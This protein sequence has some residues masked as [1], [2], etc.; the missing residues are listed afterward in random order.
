MS[1]SKL[2]WLTAPQRIID[3]QAHLSVLV[4]PRLGAGPIGQFDLG[5]WPE[6]LLGMS[7]ELRTRSGG[8]Q[9]PADQQPR[10]V[11]TPDL[12]VWQAFFSGDAGVVDDTRYRPAPPTPTVAEVYRDAVQTHETHRKLARSIAERGGVTDEAASE[13]T[14]EWARRAPRTA[15]DT[16]SVPGAPHI[17]FNRAV[18]L[19]REHP[20]VMRA[21]GL[22]FDLEI[23]ADVLK[24][25]DPADRVLSVTSHDPP[26]PVVAPW[27]RY[28]IAYDATHQRDVL[29]TADQDGSFH[30]RGMLD[31]HTARPVSALHRTPDGNVP[32]AAEWVISTM[33]VEGAVG[34]LTE[35]AA[36]LTR[37]D[38]VLLPRARSAGLAL[39]RPG[40]QTD[41]DT[42]AQR[43]Q[44]R[45]ADEEELELASDD[46]LLGY[47]VDIRRAGSPWRSVCE[48]DA[49]YAVRAG[50]GTWLTI[51]VPGPEE[52]HVKPHSMLRREDGTLETDEVV[53]RWDGWSLALPQPMAQRGT[54]HTPT[55]MPYEF[56]WN[57][58]VPRDPAGK[59]RATLPA[60]RFGERYRM[61]VRVEDVTGGGPRLEEA[62]ME[63]A[64]S[65]QVIYT[66]HE[67]VEPPTLD[68]TDT[69]PSGASS[70]VLV[71]SSDADDDHEPVTRR[72]LSPPMGSFRLAEQHRKFDDPATRDLARGAFDRS[73]RNVSPAVPDPAVEG[74]CA[75]VKKEPGGLQEDWSGESNW[76]RWPAI[77][78]KT[79]ELIGLAGPDAETSLDFRNDTLSVRLPRAEQIT[80]ELSSTIDSDCLDHF[81]LSGWI[82]GP[83]DNPAWRED[84][85][86]GRHP[87]LSTVRRL[88]FIHVVKRPLVEPIWQL[89]DI[90]D[91]SGRDDSLVTLAREPGTAFVTLA[92]TFE[93]SGLDTDST[94]RLEVAARWTEYTDTGSTDESVEQLHAATITRGAPQIPAFRHEFGDTKHRMITY[95]LTA[96]SRYRH[97]FPDS[98]TDDA[99]TRSAI[100]PHVVNV[101][102]SARPR[103]PRVLATVPAFE[104]QT[105][106]EPDRITRTRRVALRVE[107]ARPWLLTGEGEQLAVLI[108]PDGS[109][110]DGIPTTRMG[111]DPIV[112]SAP[113]PA[114]PPASWFTGNNLRPVTVQIPGFD[115][116]LTAIPHDV[117]DAGDH[118]YA[119]VWLDIPDALDAY[120]PFVQLVVARYQRD[121]IE[122]IETSSVV[123]CD[124]IRLL[125]HRRLLVERTAQGLQVTVTGQGPSPANRVEAVLDTL[126]AHFDPGSTDLLAVPDSPPEPVAAWRAHTD[127]TSIGS[128]GSTLPPLRFPEPSGHLRLRVREIDDIPADR[129]AVG[130]PEITKQTPYFDT[131]VLPPSWNSS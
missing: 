128:T 44:T 74:V 77:G 119:D 42:L 83:S 40:R 11:S 38:P 1:T 13:I 27:T 115:R 68:G 4:V 25:G 75:F 23:D 26:V 46:L 118:W 29:H 52:G 9:R 16:R 8:E 54:R 105:T 130:P 55:A 51:G 111:R 53:L 86:N 89:P 117:H 43:A 30:R 48:R 6:Q 32:D 73:A 129:S 28:A 10:L 66:R 63:D 85:L 113:V 88:T 104:W 72:R 102:S 124:T 127:S 97:F 70:D 20:A 101:L 80:V 99:F 3:G 82:L 114:S 22:V 125:P 14:N 18:A 15:H 37:G 71:V 58:D 24:V 108:A 21:L 79:I 62:D 126:P 90:A 122:G 39:V 61:R 103:P 69:L 2:I 12:E 100:Q 5:D 84:A 87:M 76:P 34:S 65:P 67:P 45:P 50:D 121:S 41:Y 116:S 49:S 78:S 123:T 131:V 56:E 19:L 107:L 31:I 95:Q 91:S 112:V 60:L 110:G 36:A 17:D 106:H 96:I 120:A 35:A 92:P 93:P 81:A 59:P 47:R 7:F 64:A 109:A 94:A 98:E 33:D 57:F